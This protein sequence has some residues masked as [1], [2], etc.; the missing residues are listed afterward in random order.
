MFKAGE[1][2]LTYKISYCNNP[3]YWDRESLANTLDQVQRLQNWTSD[4]GLLCLRFL[5][6]FLDTS[7]SNK[8]DLLF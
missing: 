8:M 6:K 4:Q 5:K 1:K 7:I 2:I 3:K